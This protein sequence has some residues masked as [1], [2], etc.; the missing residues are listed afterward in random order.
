M[1]LQF[2]HQK[3]QADAATAVCDVFAGQPYFTPTYTIAKGAGTYQI[4]PSK[5]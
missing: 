2:K 3:F 5:N 1:K 4:E